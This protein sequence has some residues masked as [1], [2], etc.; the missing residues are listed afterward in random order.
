MATGLLVA[1]GELFKNP[2]DLFFVEVETDGGGETADGTDD[3]SDD[4]AGDGAL[5]R[6]P[7]EPERPLGAR[8]P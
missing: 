4:G 1:C 6:R 2:F 5:E 7:A 8:R 3:G